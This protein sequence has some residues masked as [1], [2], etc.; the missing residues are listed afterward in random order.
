MWGELVMERSICAIGRSLSSKAGI[1][2]SV[3]RFLIYTPHIAPRIGPS[4][5]LSGLINTRLLFISSK[6]ANHARCIFLSPR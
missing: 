5:P 2:F 1:F 6:G 4:V 3:L